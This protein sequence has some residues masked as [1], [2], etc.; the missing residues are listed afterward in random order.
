[1]AF[2]PK[3]YPSN[4][5]DI[6]LSIKD[7]AGWRCVRCGHPHEK[8]K[9]RIPCDGQCD[10]TRHPGG[11]NDGRQRILTIHHLDGDKMNSSWWNL[12]PL[13]QCCHLSVQARVRLERPWFGEHSRW[14]RVYVAGW[15]AWRYLGRNLSRE[16]VERRLD[17]LLDLERKHNHDHDK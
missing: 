15:Y 13:C 17:E 5:D 7:N 6:K 4:W 11:L 2:N 12:A 10:P 8:R 3:D 1:M 9:E 14:F 16:Q